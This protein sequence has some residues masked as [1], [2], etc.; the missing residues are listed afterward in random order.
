MTKS[1]LKWFK[2]QELSNLLWATAKLKVGEQNGDDEGFDISPI[3]N[4]ISNLVV[5]TISEFT[6]QG[7]SN[8][9]WSLANLSYYHEEVIETL[10]STIQSRR[11]EFNAQEMSNILWAFAKLQVKIASLLESMSSYL[12]QNIPVF[13]EQ[14]IA[15]ILWALAKFSDDDSG[16]VSDV[17]DSI[18]AQFYPI[19]GNRA[20]Q[21]NNQE[22]SMII[23][24]LSVLGMECKAK[25]VIKRTDEEG[26]TAANALLAVCKLKVN[27]FS[28]Q[29]IS[30]VSLGFAKLG[31]KDEEFLTQ[32][33]K[34]SLVRLFSIRS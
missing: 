22:L 31:I 24:A 16:T 25:S 28:A 4:Q 10:I 14:H 1:K 6:P 26:K 20:Q 21:F 3:L 32:V 15:N 17:I 5:Q 33:A 18:V 12:I 27:K 7:I 30:T 11:T 2:P 23:W 29:Q 34:S 9:C 19:L 13:T 8:T